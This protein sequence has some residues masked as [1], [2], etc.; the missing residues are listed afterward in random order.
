M[1]HLVKNEDR[2]K[3][4]THVRLKIDGHLKKALV[5]AIIQLWIRQNQITILQLR[6]K[7]QSRR[8]LCH[9]SFSLKMNMI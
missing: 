3:Q 7:C 5:Q 4:L 1:Q 8:F 9:R 6:K 2:N